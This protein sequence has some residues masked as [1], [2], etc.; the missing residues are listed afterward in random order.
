[1]NAAAW[2]YYTNAQC[3]LSEEGMGRVSA[4]YECPGEGWGATPAEVHVAQQLWY[5]FWAANAL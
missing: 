1:M 3:W 5:A 4:E 2:A